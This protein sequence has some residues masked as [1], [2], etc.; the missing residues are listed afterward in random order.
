MPRHAL[1]LSLA[2]L[3]AAAQPVLV[4]AAGAEPAAP[5]ASAP[6]PAADADLRGLLMR[7]DENERALKASP[8]V[9]R[10][11]ALNGYIRSVLCRAV[12]DAKCASVRLYIL[13][14]PE[15]NAA[16]AP[17]GMMEVYSGLL[18]RTHNEAQ[19]AAVLGHEYTHFENQHTLKLYLDM[20]S[21]SQEAAWLAFTGIGLIASFSLMGSVSQYSRDMEHEA[22]VGGLNKMATAG[23]DT[24]EAA[25]VWEQLRAEM[26]ATALAR[27][28]QSRKDKNGGFFASHPPTA[29]RVSYLK[30]AATH[31][32]GKPGET[33]SATWNEA[34]KHWWPVF[35]DDQLKRNDF[36]AGDYL[37]TSSAIDG[38]TPWL[39]YARGEL[40]RRRGGPGDY[41]KAIGFYN[42]ALA[43][44]GDL[45][46]ILRGRGLAELKNGA[47]SAGK[48][49]L[50][51]YLHRAPDAD[52]HSLIAMMAGGS[53]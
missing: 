22:D 3:V 48:A 42:E 27:N 36:G 34:M 7:V 44:G 31:L 20:K 47:V 52:D 39:L 26:D 45:P 41:D 10:D 30:D 18:L 15:F 33:G 25:A 53:A 32:P 35:L 28:T 21:K 6:D 50:T 49:D 37:L 38:W 19:L 46:E 1:L 14:T 11:P 24:R 51:E 12:G 23:Y 29:E 8:L 13:R 5:A 40:Y 2:A 43:K 17:N 9:I 16:M 4:Q